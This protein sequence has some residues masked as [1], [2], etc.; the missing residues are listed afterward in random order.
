M[1]DGGVRGSAPAYLRWRR[2][3]RA[4]APASWVLAASP[5]A[6]A[7]GHNPPRERVLTARRRPCPAPPRSAPAAASA[8]TGRGRRLSACL[9][10]P[11]GRGISR[12]P[13][14]ATRSPAARCVCLSDLSVPGGRRGLRKNPWDRQELRG[15]VRHPGPA[16]VELAKGVYTLLLPTQVVCCWSNGAG[17]LTGGEPG[18]VPGPSHVQ[19]GLHP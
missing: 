18:L 16:F 6:L 19:E 17:G 5:V 8:A 4:V 10:P 15:G 13:P 11:R 14:L 3:S 7:G 1:K 9:P 12:T 2:R